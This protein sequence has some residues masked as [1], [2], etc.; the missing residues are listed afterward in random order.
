MA[1]TPPPDIPTA[2]TTSSLR[3]RAT[4]AVTTALAGVVLA[5]L[6]VVAPTPADATPQPPPA[7]PNG[8]YLFRDGRFTP[9]GGVPG[10]QVTAHFNLN[11]RGQVVGLYVDAA[12]AAATPPGRLPTVRSFVK[13]RHGRVTTFT[14]SGASATVACGIN[15]FGQIAGTYRDAGAG[16]PGVPAPPGTVHGFVRQPGGQITTIDLPGFTDTQLSDINNRGQLV[17]KANDAQGRRVGFLRDPGGKVTTIVLPGGA[18]SDEILAVNDRGQVAG[19]WDDRPQTRT[20]EP[21]SFHG[22]VWDRGRLTRFDVPGS[23]ATGAL[24]I[25]NAGQV[26][27]SFDDTRGH[28]GFVRQPSGRYTTIDAPGRMV[29]DAWGVNDRGHIVI[30]ELG[31]GLGPVTS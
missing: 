11:N 8:A 21:G 5:A 25:N 30:P 13:D 15:D 26:T 18:L 24:G 14:V 6:V 29:T 7:D 31:T 28:H 1:S 27:G 23:L 2:T 3:R 12:D 20:V 4:A 10:A 22:F 19:S 16:V 9:L 17:G